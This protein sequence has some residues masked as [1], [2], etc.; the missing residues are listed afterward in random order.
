MEDF[1]N[2]LKVRPAA[3]DGTKKLNV[4]Q[5]SPEPSSNGNGNGAANGAHTG[6]HNG[7]H[8]VNSHDA[9][10]KVPGLSI[11][12]SK[13]HFG[14]TDERKVRKGFFIILFCYIISSFQQHVVV[15]HT[16]F[17]PACGTNLLQ[18]CKKGGASLG[19]HQERQWCLELC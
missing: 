16:G 12:M 13:V 17:Y 6:V 5:N 3:E 8:P 1:L 18:T 14:Y 11:E 2:I 19:Q 4:F 15:C 7:V 9:C 10:P